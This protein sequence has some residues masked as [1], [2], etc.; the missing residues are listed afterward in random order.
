MTLFQL[1]IANIPPARVLL[2]D[3]CALLDKLRSLGHFRNLDSR[4]RREWDHEQ[5]LYYVISYLELLV[6]GLR[7]EKL[8]FRLDSADSARFRVLRIAATNNAY[9]VRSSTDLLLQAAL[10][11][12]IEL[13]RI[14]HAS[15]RTRPSPSYPDDP[16]CLRQDLDHW[17]AVFH[18][19]FPSEE[20]VPVIARLVCRSHRFTH[21][22]V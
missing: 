2:Q 16:D 4:D 11:L 20:A 8:D 12:Q 19:I 15:S 17:E 21:P 6:S 3:A 5:H 10:A 7:A 1:N 22:F 18:A 9:L 14:M 13:Y